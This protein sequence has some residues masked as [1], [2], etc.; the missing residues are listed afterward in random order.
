MDRDAPDGAEETI[1]ERLRRLR[2]ERGLS[3][4]ELSSP[5]VSYAYI[6]RIE[7]GARR[8]SV[9]A[10]RMLAR[11]LEVSAEYLE[12]G[13]E[14]RTDQERELQLADLELAIRLGGDAALREDELRAILR[15]S[16]A[17]GDSASAARA[18]VALGM[19]AASQNRHAEAAQLLAEAVAGGDVSPTDR[20]DVFLTLGYAYAFAGD[21]AR[22]A[23]LWRHCLE[24]VAAEAPQDVPTQIRFA[25]YLSYALTDLGDYTGAHRVLDEALERSADVNDPYTRVRLYWSLGRLNSEEGRPT[26]AL[27]YLRRAIAL[28][29]ATE[30]TL[31]LAK[32]HL[33][34][35][36]TLI[37]NDRPGEAEPYLEKAEQ[38]FGMHAA[39]ADL[40]SLR[41]E[42]AK[43]AARSGRSD[44][45]LERAQQTLELV[46]DNKVL[47]RGEALWASAEAYAQKGEIDRAGELFREAVAEMSESGRRRDVVDAMRAWARMLRENGR[48]SDA[49]D[50]LEQAAQLASNVKAPQP[51]AQD[52]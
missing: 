31:H 43:A 28:L 36:A 15:D 7:A 37:S 42:Q 34:C 1:G 27:N 16:V 49:L 13:S 38:L 22:A 2:L 46:G 26:A 10:L 48:E 9:K 25:T 35:G 40:A 50:V 3:Q 39:P 17:D 33:A 20:P 32:A 18:R 19:H 5:G 11:K 52:A 45:A 29:E 14:I 51:V 12:T 4:R 24:E 6:S 23:Q 8:P 44:E 21:H 41:V 47:E 30:D